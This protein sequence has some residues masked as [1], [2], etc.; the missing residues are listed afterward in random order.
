M[1]SH[2]SPQPTENT[3]SPIQSTPIVNALTDLR[4]PPY[5]IHNPRLWFAQA[6]AFFQAKRIGTEATRYAYAVSSLPPEVAADVLDLIVQVPVTN[7]YTKLKE[8]IIQRTSVSD[9]QR[10]QQLLTSCSLDDRK[11]S[12]L[13]RLMQQ[14][15]GPYKF[16]E[17]VLKHMWLR[18]L[19]YT[20]QQILSISVNST[21]L[22][23]L[24]ELADKIFDVYPT[25]QA[26]AGV[27]NPSISGDSNV[28]IE[29]LQAQVATLTTA[30]AK[31]QSSIA[32][33]TKQVPHSIRRRR[34]SSTRRRSSSH[35]PQVCWYH[36]KFGGEAKKCLKPCS[37]VVGNGNLRG[38]LLARQ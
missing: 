12:Q 34:S 14:L 37:F 21:P 31:L 19:P 27:H 35:A 26:I 24:A 30:V 6:E 17:D 36:R 33:F 32:S 4:L 16:D 23:E 10:L 22:S 25:H 1:E 7:P 20:I 38:N 2:P 9:E 5:S 18:R 28:S 15:A 29:T 3:P 8:A 13:L 11:P